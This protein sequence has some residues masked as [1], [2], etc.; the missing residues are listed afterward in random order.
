VGYLLA[1]AATGP[2]GM[3]L[4]TLFPEVDALLEG[5]ERLAETLA[6]LFANNLEME[7]TAHA[8]SIH[9]NTLAYRLGRIHAATGLDPARCLDHA[10][11][12][13]VALLMRSP[14]VLR[15]AAAGRA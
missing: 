6:A 14:A 5:R 9:R 15:P 7:A 1:E 11:L 8:L 4:H 3:L 12:L 2:G 13:R 10:I